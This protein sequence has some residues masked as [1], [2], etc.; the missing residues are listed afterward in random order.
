MKMKMKR[1]NIVSKEREI[2]T[3]KATKKKK[4]KKK[5]STTHKV[6]SFSWIIIRND[7][8]TKQTKTPANLCVETKVVSK[9]YRFALPWFQHKCLNSETLGEQ[10]KEESRY[11]LMNIFSTP[12]CPDKI[13]RYTL[14]TPEHQCFMC[15]ILFFVCHSY[16]FHDTIIRRLVSRF[17][18]IIFFFFFFLLIIYIV[19]FFSVLAQNDC[20]MNITV[21]CAL[22]GRSMFNGSHSFVKWQT[23]FG[24]SS[25]LWKMHR[26]T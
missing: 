15:H 12:L 11:L 22:F 5:P 3:A 20:W 23:I 1:K 8:K 2:G 9:I 10:A 18:I 4:K 25:T 21:T 26:Q 6:G 19:F 16:G 7:G 17:F 14:Y 13:A 24:Y